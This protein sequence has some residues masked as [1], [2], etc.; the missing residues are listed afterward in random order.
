A[1]LLEALG[2]SPEEMRRRVTSKK[3]TTEAAINTMADE[4][5][6]DVVA[7]G[8]LAAKVRSD[9]LSAD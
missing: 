8:M 6:F 7:K 9:E 3:G 4:G 5:F 2:V 1:K